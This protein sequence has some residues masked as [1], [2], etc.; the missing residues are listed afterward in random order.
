MTVRNWVCNPA[1]TTVTCTMCH[2]SFVLPVTEDQIKAWQNGVPAQKAMPLL[3]P[4]ERE[5]FISKTCGSCFDEMFA[6][7]D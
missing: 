3:S 7:S 4:G 6:G 2:E 1:D 5:L